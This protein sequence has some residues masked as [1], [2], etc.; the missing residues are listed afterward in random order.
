M[1][2]KINT[3]KR[4]I[5]SNKRTMTQVINMTVE[6]SEM[7]ENYKKYKKTIMHVK[8]LLKKIVI[9]RDYLLSCESHGD[10]F[11]VH[12]GMIKSYNI[13]IDKI[14]NLNFRS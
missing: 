2:T 12:E 3:T 6:N 7:M 10:Q 9:E 13:V 11:L 14:N 1:I 5:M 8:D 4:M